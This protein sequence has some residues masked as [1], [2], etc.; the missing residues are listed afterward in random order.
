[1]RTKMYLNKK[2]DKFVDKYGSSAKQRSTEWHTLIKTTV[3]GSEI[4]TVLG[5]NKYK[6][7]YDLA[8]E[9]SGLAPGFTGNMATYWGTVFED[10][11]G[12]A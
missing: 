10:V 1:M 11:I 4:S 5:L 7:K 2:I 12:N 6:T 8:K 9:K 3:G